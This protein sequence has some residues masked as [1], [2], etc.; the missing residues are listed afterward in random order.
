MR[1]FRLLR[2]DF[3]ELIAKSLIRETDTCHF[4]GTLLYCHVKKDLREMVG[5]TQCGRWSRTF[6]L[7]HAPYSTIALFSTGPMLQ[8]SA[9]FQLH[10]VLSSS[11][12]LVGFAI[13]SYHWILVLL[14]ILCDF[15]G[16]FDFI[17]LV[18]VVVGEQATT[19]LWN[20]DF[21]RPGCCQSSMVVQ[22][23]SAFVWEFDSRR[24]GL[25]LTR[26][27]LT[28]I[29][30]FAHVILLYLFRWQQ[31][32]DYSHQHAPHGLAD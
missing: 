13:V 23:V 8:K 30:S 32:T 17:S 11:H 26:T 3:S 6:G 31:H 29:L 25:T 20:F 10:S 28:W 5:F 21:I 27:F 14:P 1:R 12:W 4:M 16:Y 19:Q 18:R 2:D 7:F 9:R 15:I 22:V 24:L